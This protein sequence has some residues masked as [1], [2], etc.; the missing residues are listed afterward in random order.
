MDH[1]VA[2]RLVR[3]NN[4][5]AAQRNSLVLQKYSVVSRHGQ[6]LVG[7][8]GITNAAKAVA[9]PSLM[10]VFAVCADCQKFG[11]R[12][13]KLLQVIAKRGDLGGADESEIHGIE[14]QDQPVP[15]IGIKAHIKEILSIPGDSL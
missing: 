10:R 3:I 13:I 6:G 8:Q 7:S 4:K 14:E 1:A 15:L 5:Q 12:F 2:D 9:D 11:I